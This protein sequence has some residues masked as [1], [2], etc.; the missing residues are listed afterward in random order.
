MLVDPEIHEREHHLY[1]GHVQ[2]AAPIARPW[3]TDLAHPLVVRAR[4]AMVAAGCRWTEWGGDRRDA[5]FSS[6]GSVAAGELG[7]PALGYGPGE[8]R[9]ANT[10]NESVSLLALESATYGSAMLALGLCSGR[11]RDQS[12]RHRPGSEAAGKL[13]LSALR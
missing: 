2:L 13:E 4:E 8:R 12:P 9:Q 5:G 3:S 1:T 10:C 7:L 6:S 11:R